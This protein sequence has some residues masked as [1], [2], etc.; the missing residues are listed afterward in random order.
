MGND[1][2]HVGELQRMVTS[3]MHIRFVWR[4]DYVVEGGEQYVG[5]GT[6]SFAG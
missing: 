5:S 1:A 6:G 2:Q 3:R 4:K